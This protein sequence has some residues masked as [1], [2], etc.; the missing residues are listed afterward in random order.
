MEGKILHLRERYSIQLFSHVIAASIIALYISMCRIVSLS[1]Q[2][3]SDKGIN[4]NIDFSDQIPPQILR[5][6]L[7]VPQRKN[8]DLL[9][10]LPSRQIDVLMVSATSR[11]GRG[12]GKKRC[13]PSL[14]HSKPCK[15]NLQP[16]TI[17]ESVSVT[18]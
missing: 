7:S 12:F 1:I 3:Y 14:P 9:C 10:R 8:Q 16:E 4:E 13:Q 5:T 15:L 18:S 2:K 6:I 11:C 17:C